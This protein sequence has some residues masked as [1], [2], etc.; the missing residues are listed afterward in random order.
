MCLQTGQTVSHFSHPWKLIIYLNLIIREGFISSSHVLLS[1]VC[2]IPQE[3]CC[4]GRALLR[5]FEKEYMPGNQ[6]HN[7]SLSLS[8]SLSLDKVDLKEIC[9]LRAWLDGSTGTGRS[10]VNRVA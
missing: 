4:F 7:L 3:G 10:G 8:L 2:R 1:L 9:P 6:L 5:D